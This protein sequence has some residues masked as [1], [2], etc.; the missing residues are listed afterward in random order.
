MT[1]KTFPIQN[2]GKPLSTPGKNAF[3]VPTKALA[4]AI[5]AEWRT[6][7]KF[8]PQKMPLTLLAYTAIDRIAGQEAQIVEVLLAYVDTDTLSYRASNEAVHKKQKE[9]WNPVL[10]WAGS[11][12]NA[13][14]QTTTGVMPLEQPQALHNAI[15]AYLGTLDAMQLSA[16]CILA[17]GYSSLALA[18]AVLKGYKNAEEAFELSRLEEALQAEQWGKDAEADARA[19][20][21]KEE[22]SS[23]GQFLRL[24]AAA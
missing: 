6:H 24:L 12:F 13:L 7:K 3:A 15:A 5:E 22:L 10:A 19:Q 4:D 11:Q 21:V 8:S 1:Q 23:A 9:L 18:L 2:D 14:W 17:S 16:A 20:R